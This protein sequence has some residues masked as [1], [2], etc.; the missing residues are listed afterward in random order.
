MATR[1]LVPERGS[2]ALIRL[3]Q[4]PIPLQRREVFAAL[5]FATFPAAIVVLTTASIW[6]PVLQ[7]ALVLAGLRA[8]AGFRAGRPQTVLL[9]VGSTAVLLLNLAYGVSYYLQNAG[10]NRS[11]FY[12][13]RP[14]V[15]YA[16]LSEF[17][18]AALLSVAYVAGSLGMVRAA[19]RRAPAASRAGRLA[20]V[21]V[22][23]ASVLLFP[24]LRSMHGYVRDGASGA[25]DPVGEVLAARL[26]LAPEVVAP[27]QTRNLVLIYVESLERS[28][29]DPARFPRLLP[30]LHSLRSRSLEFTRIRQVYGTGWTVGGIVA[31]QCGVPLAVRYDLDGNDF[32]VFTDFLPGGTCLAD[33]LERHGYATTYMG[34]ADARFGGKGRFLASHGFGRVLDRPA[35]E[36]RL[37]PG[38]AVH[39]WGLQDDDLFRLAREEF[40]D[41]AQRTR[42]FAL[43]LLTLDTHHPG[44]PSPS[45]A[46]YPERDV[47]IL[48]AAHCTDQLVSAFIDSVRASPVS[49]ETTIVVM[50]D[51]LA[52]R[53]AVSPLLEAEPDDRLL[54]LIIDAPGQ[55]A[56]VREGEGT[57]FDV[58]PTVM[59]SL[60]FRVRGSWGLGHSLLSHP[61]GWLTSTTPLDRA[62]V[63][64]RQEPLATVWDDLWRDGSTD[65]RRIRVDFQQAEVEIQGSTYSLEQHR[66]LNDLSYGAAAPAAFE[67]DPRDLSLIRVHRGAFWPPRLR[68]IFF[69]SPDNLFLITAPADAFGTLLDHGGSSHAW[70]FL[71]IVP[72]ATTA[73]TGALDDVVEIAGAR[74]DS[75]LTAPRS[76]QVLLGRLRSLR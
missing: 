35:L 31:S 3:L 66:R 14:D 18:V 44:Y 39:A 28:Y 38:A 61:R 48:H 50:S 5:A 36:P 10:F 6:W 27:D 49:D 22:L 76:Q 30:E 1:D 68:R 65:R 57:S 75:V 23:A 4:R 24:P 56:D 43:V 13:L 12:H 8:L 37:S 33:I 29:F 2:A 9:M 25:P 71:L 47:G 70:R 58:A 72:T 21:G 11:F 67:L 40:R 74:I 42:P 55:E 73:V 45:C 19:V 16:G 59:E 53:N 41:L 54:T 32:G 51:H 52:M 20:S 64:M 17:G 7:A 63:A 34:G 46:P 15:V 62:E 26:S 69:D 60:G